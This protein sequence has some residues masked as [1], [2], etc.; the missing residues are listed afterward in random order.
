MTNSTFTIGQTIEATVTAP[1]SFYKRVIGEIVEIKSNGFIQIQAT[2]VISKYS[3]SW[4]DHPT[5]CGMSVK[6]ENVV[7]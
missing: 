3:D 7:R 2:K 4:K 6:I 5:S 1:S